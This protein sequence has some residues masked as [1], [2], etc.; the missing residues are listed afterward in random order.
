MV[1]ACIFN[2][3]GIPELTKSCF[4]GTDSAFKCCLLRGLIETTDTTAPST[5]ILNSWTLTLLSGDG[6]LQK[7]SQEQAEIEYM[8]MALNE[9]LVLLAIISVV[10][11]FV[12]SV[13][14]GSSK[15]LRV[16]T[17][18]NAWGVRLGQPIGINTDSIAEIDQDTPFST[19]QTK[20][21]GIDER[22]LR[23]GTGPTDETDWE[24]V[25]RMDGAFRKQ[26]LLKTLQMDSL[27][28]EHKTQY[29]KMAADQ[30]GIL[31]QSFGSS[32]PTNMHAGGLMNDWDFDI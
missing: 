21:T 10:P 14:P 15:G 17:T 18:L 12:R 7:N 31:P 13:L 11:A 28:A 20:G 4:C 6:I 29:I 26:S 16:M 24:M 27:S 23:H 5:E 1:Y 30:E 25:S 22:K 32:T 19:I 8:N 2:A 9:F 3:L